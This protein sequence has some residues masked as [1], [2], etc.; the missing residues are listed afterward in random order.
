[1]DEVIENEDL[2]KEIGIIVEEYLSSKV[3]QSIKSGDLETAQNI[4]EAAKTIGGTAGKSIAKGIEAD[5]G[6]KETL[7]KYERARKHEIN[8]FNALVQENFN[9]ALESF[10]EAS[11]VYPKLHSVSEISRLLN[12]KKD[13]FD[14][15]EVQKDIYRT[16]VEKYSWKVPKD[17]VQELKNK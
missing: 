12:S 5:T 16:I 10:Q 6:K 14:N 11:D 13:E 8:G 2:K 9:V 17:I 1:M 7:S 3:D 15:I 4:F